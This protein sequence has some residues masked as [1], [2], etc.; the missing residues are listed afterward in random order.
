MLDQD[1]T[2]EDWSFSVWLMLDQDNTDED[3]SFSV[4]VDCLIITTWTVCFA[5]PFMNGG[6]EQ[7]ER[8]GFKLFDISWR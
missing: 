1:N 3:W 6:I 5:N 8:D 2:D 4:P 7:F